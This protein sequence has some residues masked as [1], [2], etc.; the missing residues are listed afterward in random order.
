[1][2]EDLNYPVLRECECGH[3]HNCTR[4]VVARLVSREPEK[5]LAFGDWGEFYVRSVKNF[6]ISDEPP[7]PFKSKFFWK[8]EPPEST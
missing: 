1:M 8:P 2:D 4:E 6:I 3:Q 7:Y 5:V